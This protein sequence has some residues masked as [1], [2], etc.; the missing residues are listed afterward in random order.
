[1]ARYNLR[2]KLEE[3]ILL[4]KD[5][6]KGYDE[7]LQDLKR[8]DEKHEKRL[9]GYNVMPDVIENTHITKEFV[10]AQRGL[11]AT[12]D[13]KKRTEEAEVIATLEELRKSFISASAEIVKEIEDIFGYTYKPH[14][15][16]VDESVVK[17]IEDGLYTVKDL[18][19]L[20]ENYKE[21]R[22][23][24]MMRI[25]AHKGREFALPETRESLFF[26]KA[27]TEASEVK[28]P[29]YAT[30]TNSVVSAC[31]Y[32]MGI[33]GKTDIRYA[34]VNTKAGHALAKGWAKKFDAFTEKNL[35][36][37]AKIEETV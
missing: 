26:E 34:E 37:A 25:V 3:I 28:D 7:L 24:S 27:Y 32:A 35:E 17:G 16:M 31:N 29:P 22:N 18:K 11:R 4:Y 8:I 9:K 14:P 10:N 15:E 21:K 13:N 5:H 1:M 12:I 23:I 6:R 2:D 30:I 19:E 20:Y 36:E 33:R